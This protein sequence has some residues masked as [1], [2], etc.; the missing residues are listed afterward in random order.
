MAGKDKAK[1]NGTTERPV[2]VTTQHRGVFFGF[3]DPAELDCKSKIHLTRVRNCIFWH[4]SVGGFLGLIAIIGIAGVALRM[5][6]VFGGFFIVPMYLYVA[7]AA[8]LDRPRATTL[9][10]GCAELLGE[11]KLLR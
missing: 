2:L 9:L 6:G 5:L 8:L 10:A 3:A 1:T 11:L 7:I 4:S